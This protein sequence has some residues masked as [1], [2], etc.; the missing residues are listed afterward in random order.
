MTDDEFFDG[1]EAVLRETARKSDHRR[2]DGA[3]IE[4]VDLVI[5]LRKVAGVLADHC[6]TVLMTGRGMWLEVADMLDAAARSC[7]NEATIDSVE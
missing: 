1:L 7:R 3:P 2:F 4:Q 6:R 5:E